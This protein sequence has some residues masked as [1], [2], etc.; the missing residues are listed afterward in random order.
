MS[1]SRKLYALIISILTLMVV[2]SIIGI[3]YMTKVDQQVDA[4]TKSLTLDSRIKEIRL[5]A[6]ALSTPVHDY[7]RSG[8]PEAKQKYLDAFKRLNSSI[9]V[10]AANPGVGDC[11][12]CHKLLAS[13]PKDIKNID[14]KA[15]QI[16]SLENPTTNPESTIYI[17][18]L[19]KTITSLTDNLALVSKLSKNIAANASS[20]I[21]RIQDEYRIAITLVSI[22]IILLALSISF[23]TI[24][25][26]TKRIK[27]LIAVTK[28]VAA[29]KLEEKAN[30]S[31]NDELGEL[32][33][34][35]NIMTDTLLVSRIELQRLNEHLEQEV[36]KR[37]CELERLSITDS[38]T[39]LYNQRNFYKELEKEV[40]RALRQGHD[41]FIIIF[42]IDK[43][44][45][46]NDDYGHVAGDKI[47]ITVGNVTKESIRTGVD[48]AYRYG[49]DEFTII[50]PEASETQA[51]EIGNRLIKNLNEHGIKVSMG[52]SS[53][54]YKTQELEV[55]L[56]QADEAMYAAKRS[57]GNKILSYRDI[58]GKKAV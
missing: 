34:A 22:L 56:K 8:N 12:S 14:T 17:K 48:S 36:W 33:N 27:Q 2:S 58:A 52:L 18:D 51:L 42:D 38:L 15:Q 5:N 54:T 32:A 20:D 46:Y 53:C 31:S 25:S 6:E 45:K 7:V 37:T 1:I 29:G 49:G 41:L 23:V 30:F 3:I 39:G 35:F 44:K 10:C 4:L 28:S 26:I 40:A 57:G 21:K 55:F 9:E 13:T 47:L 16:F 24:R 43:F 11:T 50:I 19:D